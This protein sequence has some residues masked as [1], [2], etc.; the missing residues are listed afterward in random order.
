[1]SI[2]S[3]LNGILQLF[4]LA[5]FGRLILDYVRMFSPSWRPRGIV[6]F[7]AEIIYG[8]TDPVMKIARRY[9]PPLRLGP[10]ALD[11]SFLVIFFGVQI[12]S[13]LTRLIP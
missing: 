4:I 5:L 7:I 8:A 3:I 6:L 10:V 9:I 1:M 2:G 11:L 12:L 13:S